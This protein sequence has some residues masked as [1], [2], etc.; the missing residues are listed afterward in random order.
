VFD[1]SDIIDG[2]YVVD[3]PCSQA[4]GMGEILFV[5]PVSG[6]PGF[7]LAL[8][9][10]KGDNEEVLKRFRREVR[11]LSIFKGNSRV[12]QILD[13]NLDYDPPYFVMK[14]YEDGDLLAI[15]EEIRGSLERQEACFLKMIECIEELHSRNE[16]HR[17]IKPQNFL[18]EGDQ[19]VVSDLGLSTEVGSATAFTTSSIF[20]GTHGYIP[21]EFLVKGGFKSPDASG[22]VYMLG[23]TF[24]VLIT[25]REPMY[26]T[27]EGIPPPLFHV[28]ERCAAVQK[29]DRYQKLA[30][31]KQSLVVAYDVLLGRAGGKVHQ[32][33]SL[34]K[35][36]F[37]KDHQ[38]RVDEMSQFIEQLSLTA[39][40]EAIQLCFDLPSVFFAALAQKP[41]ASQLRPFLMT[42]QALVDG[43]NYGWGYAEVIATNMKQVF[44]SPDAELRD[45]AMALDFAIRAAW[46]KNRFAA[47]DTCRS[48]V[49]SVDSEELGMHVAPLL[50]KHQDTFIGDIEISACHCDPVRNALRSIKQ[51]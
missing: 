45:R 19:I 5:T 12:V 39:Q 9:Y 4:G 32:L 13:E 18:R 6:S 14:Y 26:I 20:W 35:E 50:L 42:Y 37:E 1:P 29:A 16:Y 23:K 51:K 47:M 48:M 27:P 41:L 49:T 8:K 43:G 44:R 33:Y 2:K 31:L 3:G 40:A 15:S 21:P 25:G 11:L 36:R 10:C 24:Y 46:M 22:D 34:I 38:Y 30:D 7:R 17:D 28:I